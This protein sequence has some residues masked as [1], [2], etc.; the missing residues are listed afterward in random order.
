MSDYQYFYVKT[1]NHIIDQHFSLLMKE[2]MHSITFASLSPLNNTLHRLTQQ[3][4]NL[5]NHRNYTPLPVTG[6]FIVC[7]I[8]KTLIYINHACYWWNQIWQI[9]IV[10]C[11]LIHINI[12]TS[13]GNKITN[14]VAQHFSSHFYINTSMS[15]NVSENL[16]KNTTDNFFRKNLQTPP[17]LTSP[18]DV[19][20][21]I[22]KFLNKKSPE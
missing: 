21:I 13:N 16:A 20:D 1:N 12:V 15:C 22:Y 17:T 3:I 4:R 2:I 19:N 14:T 9:L 11:P 6:N 5:I 7:N 18:N 10:K 8:L